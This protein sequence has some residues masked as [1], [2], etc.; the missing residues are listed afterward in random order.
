[1]INFVN[2]GTDEAILKSL[3]TENCDDDLVKAMNKQGMVQKE[4]QVRGKN[5]TFTRKQWVRASE[6]AASD[7]GSK[8]TNKADDG[9]GK[10][11]GRQML[12]SLMKLSG[13][14]EDGLSMKDGT[15]YAVSHDFDDINAKDIFVKTTA[16]KMAD[17]D[18]GGGK[19]MSVKEVYAEVMKDKKSDGGSG[20]VPSSTSLV[21]MTS[22]YDSLR[23]KLDAIAPSGELD[24]SASEK[25]KEKYNSL[26]KQCEK[27]QNDIITASKA[28]EKHYGGN[29]PDEYDELLCTSP[30]DF[31]W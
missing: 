20:K 14:E 15:Y 31:S 7:G 13:W 3:P 8:S 9:G 1:M 30:E 21:R 26:M 18:I 11:S 28:V 5:G 6:A 23:D 24:D 19:E 25:T 10:K 29:I 4:V 22:K 2:K 12:D 17:G 27:V 16:D